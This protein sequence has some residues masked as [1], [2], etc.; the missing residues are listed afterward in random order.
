MSKWHLYSEFKNGVNIGG[1][2]QYVWM[3]G[4]I[5]I[6]VLLLA[7]INFMNLSTARSEKRAKEVGIRKTIGS[8]TQTTDISIFQ[9][10]IINSSFCI[11]IIIVIGTS[12]LLPFFNKVSDKQMS[13][14][15]NNPFFWL[16]MHC[17]ILFT[18]L[19]AGSYPAFY[20]SSF[21]PV[22]VLKGTFK[23]GR[24]AAI[25]RKVLVV[26]QFTVSSCTDN[27]NHYRLSANSICKKSSCR[28]FSGNDLITI[29]SSDEYS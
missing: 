15:W 6:F 22:K 23:A 28:I 9:R 14:L 21:K 17:F 27:W 19:I 20:L 5:G 10:I 12:L 24:F 29:P 11:C 4:I 2:I 25:P 18:A 13:V 16:I 1:A 8:L 3:F 7:C 26:L